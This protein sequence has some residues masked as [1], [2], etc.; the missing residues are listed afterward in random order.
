MYS[1]RRPEGR[2]GLDA[3]QSLLFKARVLEFFFLLIEALELL[4]AVL[5]LFAQTLDLVLQLA[6]FGFGGLELLL[7]AGF[8]LL[9][10]FQQFSSVRRRRHAPPPAASAFSAF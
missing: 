5:Q 1:W 3:D 4:F 2:A 6:H 10:L 7:H 9:Q 8:F